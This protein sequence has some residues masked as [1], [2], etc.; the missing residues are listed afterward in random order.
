[1]KI[2]NFG[3][4][5]E[6]QRNFWIFVKIRNFG[7]NLEF[8]RISEISAKI[9]NFYENVE[10]SWKSGIFA[11][12]RRDAGRGVRRMRRRGR[13]PIASPRPKAE[14]CDANFWL[15]MISISYVGIS[16]KPTMKNLATRWQNEQKIR[17]TTIVEGKMSENTDR[18]YSSRWF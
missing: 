8:L 16:Q 15:A 13:R 6:F 1:M 4:T 3:E 10:F 9:W 14:A 17:L 18:S 12:N 5:L 11:K 2:S 7:E